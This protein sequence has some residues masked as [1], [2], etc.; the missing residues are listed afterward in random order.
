M[1]ATATVHYGDAWELAGALEPASVDC[2]VTSPPYWKLRDYGCAGQFGREQ[3]VEDY[4]TRLVDLF[5]LLRPALK[6]T[7]T[8]WLNLGD[9]YTDGQLAGV[10]H[11][12]AFGLQ[13]AGWRLVSDLVWSSPNAMPESVTTRPTH[14]HEYIFMLTKAKAAFFDAQ[15]VAEQLSPFSE[16]RRIRTVWRIPTASYPGCHTAVFPARLVQPCIAMST[17]EAG[18]CPDCGSSWVRDIVRESRPD[19]ATSGPRSKANT[20]AGQRRASVSRDKR[21]ILAD[22][23]WRPLCECGSTPVPATVLDPFLG[24]GTTAEVAVKMGRNCIGFELNA[25]YRPLIE[26]RL[27]GEVLL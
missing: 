15:A 22:R 25:E 18:V 20:V 6:D 10:P 9:T 16:E 19:S 21:R 14:T 3:A 2:I 12:T 1:R 11:R 13:R 26:K 7:G 4:V 8:L 5:S 23:G 17:S 24:S 27:A